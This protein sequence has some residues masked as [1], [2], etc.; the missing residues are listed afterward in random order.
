LITGDACFFEESF[1]K[2]IGPGSFCSDIELAQKSLNKLFAFAQEYP[3]VQV[4]YSHQLPGDRI[5]LEKEH[6]GH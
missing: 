4:R 5:E 6:Q 3:Q 2:A 1:V